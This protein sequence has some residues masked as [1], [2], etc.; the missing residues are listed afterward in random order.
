MTKLK[1][2]SAAAKLHMAKIRA[3]KKISGAKESAALK[4]ELTKK[5]IRLPHGYETVKRT[6]VKKKI[7]GIHKDTKSHNVRINVLSGIKLSLDEKK[8]LQSEGKKSKGFKYRPKILWGD[9]I[10]L[11]EKE[12]GQPV[13]KFIV[14]SWE[15]ADYMSKQLNKGQSLTKVKGKTIK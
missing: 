4:K 12:N 7:S 1:K 2:G 14:D 5:K 11:K 8:F 3:K 13:Q 6:R 15:I 9:T 10:I